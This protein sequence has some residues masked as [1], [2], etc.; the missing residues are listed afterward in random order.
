[1]T[2]VVAF[3]FFQL[4]SIA[5]IN[6]SFCNG[7]TYVRCIESERQALL[8]FKQDLKDPS[9]RLASWIGD[10]DCCNWA[11]V[12]CH[13]VTGHV[14]Q[15][16][17][18]NP[19][20][21][22]F[23]EDYLPSYSKAEGEAYMRSKL[24][25]KI[26]PSL[27]NLKH[28]KHLDVS[29][30]DFEGIQIPGFLGSMQSLRYL[31]L[32]NARFH[33]M[34]P[35]QLGNL[36]NLQ[37]LDLNNYYFETDLYVENLRWITGLSLLKNLDLSYVN[38][39]KASHHWTMINSLPFLEVLRLSYCQLQHLS[40]IPL[41]NFSSLTTL[42][43]SSNE[44][45]NSLIPSWVFGL[46]RLIFLDLSS[47]S[48]EGPIVDGVGNLTSLRHLDLSSNHFNSSIPNW[49]SRFNRLEYLSLSYNDLQGSIS[50]A[51]V[52]LTSIMT[53]HLSHNRL[54]GRIP[55]SFGRLCNLRSISLSFLNL[56]SN[57]SDVLD[58]FVGCVSARLE[59]L[60]LSNCQLRGNLTDQLGRFKN[61]KYLSLYNN[62]IC[63]PIPSCLGELSSLRRLDLSKN[64]LNGT[65]SEIH[66]SNLARLVS[67][68]VSDNSQIVVEINFDWVPPFQL[69]VL[70]L[71]SCQLGPHFPSWLH[72]QK[73]LFN[74][75]I[76]NS[77]I[78][79]VIPDWFWNSLSQ[80]QLLNLSHNQIHQEIPKFTYAGQ[81]VVLDLS[82]NEFFGP[83]PHI[84]FDV[85]W[86]LDLSN[87]VLTGSIFQ[88]LCYGMNE[89]MTTIFLSLENNSLSGEV[90]DCWMNWK[91]LEV[92]NL[93]NNKFTGNLPPSIGNLSALQSLILRKN[94]FSG[95]IPLVSL[96]NCTELR[97]L[98]AAENQFVGNV[99]TWLTERFSR[100]KILNLRSNNFQGLLPKELCRLFS[101]QI[102][103]LACNNLSGNIP[104]CINNFS[105]MVEVDHSVS[106]AISYVNG[107]INF[108]EHA[109]LVRRGIEYEY[110]TILN[111]VRVI[112]LSKNNFSGE[113]PREVTALK[114]LQWLNLSHNSLTGRIPENI[115]AMREIQL[116][117]FS[118]NQLSS[119][120]PESI[121]NLTFLSYLN[122]ADNNLTGRIPTSTQIQGFEASCFTGNDL[123]GSPLPK[124]CTETPEHENGGGKDG[125]EEEVDW[126]YV[127]MALGFVVG[128]CGLLSP[129]LISRR[130]RYIYCGF[131]NRLED[132]I[133]I[134][135]R[136]YC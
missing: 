18:R 9:N 114:E 111:L 45:D 36:S 123:C 63:G 27:L 62:S 61:L 135:A 95:A 100:M 129:L 125:D 38:L 15:L 39:S 121:S 69:D 86:V 54:E 25:G 119:E 131:L 115:G 107:S 51:L 65:L 93:G 22:Y 40:Q 37:Y 87:N 26:N 127:S 42:D 55:T 122:L 56:N 52:N 120:I 11:G 14:L 116:I 105:A 66:F 30:N 82:S 110:S 23:E 43:L 12:D 6:F 136:K 3:L 109:S 41:A 16:Q 126:F 72:S 58:I 8:T 73:F 57:I 28:L 92:L 68:D 64:K 132:K 79:D 117:D 96:E 29:F 1:M 84:S 103:D 118:A 32:S 85:H 35:Q 124:N 2:A 74:L 48:F 91:Y 71:R 113:I 21:E 34:I 102:L 128:F 10:G 78:S 89:S 70:R 59:L 104:S 134:A 99:L 53:L 46:S 33:R 44:F 81:I 77:G 76:S 17:L 75:D 7:S 5:T 67:F 130:W 83:L 112:D 98:D 20:L 19:H 101:L 133:Y 106:K 94:N 88:F 97:V 60:Y 13:N 49:L 47:N 4:L 108:G 80:N 50:S 31:N 24:G 90:P